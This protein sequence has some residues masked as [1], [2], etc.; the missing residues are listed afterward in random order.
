[1]N[2]ELGTVGKALQ[3][4]IGRHHAVLYVSVI[5]LLIA[6]AIFSLYLVNV[7]ATSAP[8]ATPPLTSTQFD[9]ETIDRIKNL[10][11]SDGE[12][13]SV[14]LPEERANPFVE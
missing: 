11:L 8:D 3:H 13:S 9:E 14:E 2:I 1:M 4:F 10:R 5:G 7:L 12:V 6:G